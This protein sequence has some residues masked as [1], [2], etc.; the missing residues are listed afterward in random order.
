M[1]AERTEAEA[2]EV[3]AAHGHV[4]ADRRLI[5][6]LLLRALRA[7]FTFRRCFLLLL[8]LF[9]LLLLVSRSIFALLRRGLPFLALGG[10]GLLHLR[11]ALHRADDLQA[12]GTP[13]V[14]DQRHD[15]CALRTALAARRLE[16]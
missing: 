13:L 7:L 12:A 11:L 10:G 5:L 14:Q 1:M 4:R 16:Q 6:L 2:L 8:F 3:L 9:R 15:G